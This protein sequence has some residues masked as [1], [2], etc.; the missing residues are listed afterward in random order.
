MYQKLIYHSEIKSFT[1]KNTEKQKIIEF[2]QTA[3]VFGKYCSKYSEYLPG[4]FK[5]FNALVKETLDQFGLDNFEGYT[6][7][8]SSVMTVYQNLV[9]TP[10]TP[11]KTTHT[12]KHD[13]DPD[14]IISEQN[15]SRLKTLNVK[16][17][18]FLSRVNLIDSRIKLIFKRY[19]TLRFH[20]QMVGLL[21]IIG[22]FTI[23]IP[24]YPS[25]L[26]SSSTDLLISFIIP[27]F[28][29]AVVLYYTLF[30]MDVDTV[31]LEDRISSFKNHLLQ[32]K[33][34]VYDYYTKH[35]QITLKTYDDL[36]WFQDTLYDAQYFL[37]GHDLL[38]IMSQK[39]YTFFISDD[40]HP[41]NTITP[42]MEIAGKRVVKFYNHQ[43][44]HGDKELNSKLTDLVKPID[45]TLIKILGK[46]KNHSISR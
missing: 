43:K 2:G 31:K 33:S 23:A 1:S 30:G 18:V 19:T 39:R 35:P 44:I 15:K 6:G 34:F 22:Y 5:D 24:S 14:G 42:G 40:Q 17:D 37:L 21:I 27:I 41:K 46:P 25:W 38:K 45:D 20:R 3:T 10:E 32:M 36:E 7:V 12:K 16:N 28:G 8:S 26:I 13:M 29:G 4:K 9:V 11:R